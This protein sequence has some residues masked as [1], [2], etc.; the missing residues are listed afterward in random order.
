MNELAPRFS[1]VGPERAHIGDALSLELA[2]TNPNVEPLLVNGRFVVDED[3]A[4]EG[5]FEVSFAVTGPDGRP[6]EFLAEVDG[7]EASQ[8]DLVLLPPGA[9]HHGEV[10][11]DRYFLLGEPGDY[12][13]A[14]TYRNTLPYTHEGRR[15]FVGRVQAAPITVHVVG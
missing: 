13:V 10:R 14:A 3:D 6:A 7:F 8:G 15:V 2:L 9:E 11:L 5:C 4:P 1:I 12:R